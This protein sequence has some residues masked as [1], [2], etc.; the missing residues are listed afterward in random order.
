MIFGSTVFHA[1]VVNSA[2]PCSLWLSPERQRRRCPVSGPWRVEVCV[3]RGWFSFVMGV[4]PCIIQWWPWCSIETTMVTWRSLISIYLI[5]DKRCS[6]REIMGFGNW[7]SASGHESQPGFMSGSIQ[8]LSNRL[9]VVKWV[10]QNL[11]PGWQGRMHHDQFLMY[12]YST[13]QF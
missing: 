1:K 11:Q 12:V 5:Y 6:N 7:F 9:I 2:A 8:L 13:S 4:P 10:R 3:P